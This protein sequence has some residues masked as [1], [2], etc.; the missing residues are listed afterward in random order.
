[1]LKKLL[2]FIFYFS[3][4]ILFIPG[5]ATLY[6][7]ATERKEIV[8][9]DTP[10]EVSLGKSISKQVELEYPVS[11]NKEEIG[12][13]NLIG[14]KI[15]AVSD[16]K[17]LRYSFKVVENKELNAFALPGG[18]IYV[19]SGL[20]DIASDDELACVLAHEVGHIAARHAA[21]KM[22]LSLGYQ[23]IM[24]IAFKNASSP[25]LSSAVN[26]AFGIISLG[27]SREDE[28][29]ADKLAVRYAKRAEI[30]PYAMVTFFEKLKEEEKKNKVNYHIVFLESHPAIDERIQNV[31]N[32]IN[33][34]AQ[35]KPSNNN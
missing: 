20:L 8:L 12:R 13:L 28:R 25:E 19:H 31:K 18:F 9:L 5:C 34:Q 1:M 17:D 27:Y 35:D 24:S 26:T 33:K 3:F 29:L 21:K 30:N 14:A 4:F 15:A 11:E 16:R 32:E 23:L 22:Q 2:F 7:P 6:N 10:S